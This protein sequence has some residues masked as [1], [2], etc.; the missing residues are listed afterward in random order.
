MSGFGNFNF[1]S[2]GSMNNLNGLAQSAERLKRL[3]TENCIRQQ[4]SANNER[5]LINNDFFS[6][7][8]DDRNLTPPSPSTVCFN[9]FEKVPLFYRIGNCFHLVSSNDAFI[10]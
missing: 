7:S 5:I 2:F 6:S 3:M 8:N 10:I 1:N 4:E 9:V